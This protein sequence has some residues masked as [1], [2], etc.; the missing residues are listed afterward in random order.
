L[1]GDVENDGQ[2]ALIDAPLLAAGSD[3]FDASTRSSTSINFYRPGRWQAQSVTLDDLER[4]RQLLIS[5][6]GAVVKGVLNQE[7]FFATVDGSSLVI[8]RKNAEGVWR[9]V[10]VDA[11]LPNGRA[12]LAVDVNK[13]GA[14]EIVASPESPKRVFLYRAA[15]RDGEKWQRM[16][17]DDTIAGGH[18]VSAELNG[19]GKVDISC[20]DRTTP[21]SVHWYQNFQ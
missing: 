17:L 2:T 15:D 10:T 13:D 19:D 1:W 11:N 8:R 18:C 6:S 4:A 5:D 14:H 16:L 3:M 12:L 9:S 20:I 21:F 7:P